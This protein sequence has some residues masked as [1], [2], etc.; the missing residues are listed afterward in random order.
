MYKRIF[1]F[2]K[3]E[4]STWNIAVAFAQNRSTLTETWWVFKE[5]ETC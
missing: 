1:H 3:K 2:T 4:I 5:K